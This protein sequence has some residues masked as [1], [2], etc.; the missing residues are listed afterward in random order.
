VFLLYLHNTSQASF[1]VKTG[2]WRRFLEAFG[3][4]DK[5]TVCPFLGENGN[6]SRRTYPQPSGE[7][8]LKMD[9][10][11]AAIAVARED[12]RKDFLVTQFRELNDLQLA[13]VGGGIGETAL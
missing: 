7:E 8:F 6:F 9:S 5:V 11:S 3:P 2:A 10:T 13:F 12:V 1:Y 4:V